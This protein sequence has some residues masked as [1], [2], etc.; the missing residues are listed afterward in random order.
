MTKDR[1]SPACFTLP[2]Y[3][4]GTKIGQQWAKI[5]KHCRRQP[6]TI[7]R[8][9]FARPADEV[10]AKLAA[11][12]ACIRIPSGPAHAES[13]ESPL[14]SYY[15]LIEGRASR[16]LIIASNYGTSRRRHGENRGRE[17]HH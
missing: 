12:S 11:P 2:D 14:N 7:L 15:G 10:T 8:V 1:L 9:S 17:L 5:S 6:L 13:R 16:R 4:R 3:P